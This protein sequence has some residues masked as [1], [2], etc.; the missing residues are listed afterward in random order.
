MIGI[1]IYIYIYYRD[2]SQKMKQLLIIRALI[3]Q[4]RICLTFSA[5]FLW[6]FPDTFN[7]RT[8]ESSAFGLQECVHTNPVSL[9][10]VPSGWYCRLRSGSVG[11]NHEPVGGMIQLE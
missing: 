7:A 5:S 6:E 11:S 10:P 1:V 3:C 9:V 8:Q 2:L 4:T